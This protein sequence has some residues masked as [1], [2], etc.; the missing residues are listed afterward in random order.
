[1]KELKDNKR[2]RLIV[3]SC[4]ISG[5]IAHGFFMFNDLAFHDAIGSFFGES[6]IIVLS[7]RWLLATMEKGMEIIQGGSN[8]QTPVILCL[9][10]FVFIALSTYVVIK[11]MHIEKRKYIILVSVYL[12]VFPSI[13]SLFFYVYTA[14]FY[15]FGNF[16]CLLGG[17]FVYMSLKSRRWIMYFFGVGLMVASIGIYQ[18]NL[19]IVISFF[20]LCVIKTIMDD[21]ERISVK[22]TICMVVCFAG[23]MGLSVVVYILITKISLLVLK[24]Q[25]WDYADIN[26]YGV[27]SISGYIRRIICAY[28]EFVCPTN[29]VSTNMYPTFTSVIYRL[30]LILSIVVT[31]SAAVR[32]SKKSKRN[33]IIYLLVVMLLPIGLNFIYIINDASAYGI[34]LYSEAFLIVYI[35]LLLQQKDRIWGGNN[36]TVN[37]LN[38]WLFLFLVVMCAFFCKYDNDCYLKADIL[39]KQE[40]TYYTGLINSIKCTKGYSDEKKIVWVG[41]FNKQDKSIAKMERFD[42]INILP[43]NSLDEVINDYIW[44]EDLKLLCG[45]DPAVEEYSEGKFR[46]I[47]EKMTCYPDDGSIKCVDDY[48]IVKFAEP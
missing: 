22:K 28:T 43:L 30:V 14:P 10:T 29:R 23:S 48:I 47:L 18:A 41:E 32:I 21:Y 2:I 33:A 36:K 45:F 5:V 38:K 7:G 39:Q 13:T 4:I 27:T 46:G 8:C 16:I 40:L 37:I 3:L 35:V 11:A 19:G 31:M 24:L 15:L 17:Y 1:M 20:L 34:T 6:P 26:T 44:R 42:S 9:M 12:T 25:L